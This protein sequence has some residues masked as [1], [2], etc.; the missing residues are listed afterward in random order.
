MR[1]SKKN[2]RYKTKREGG[3]GG[4]LINLLVTGGITGTAL[5]VNP[6]AEPF[7]VFM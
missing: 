5:P 4:K 1:T 6:H 3:G 2:P 7:I